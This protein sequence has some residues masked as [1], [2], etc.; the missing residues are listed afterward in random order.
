GFALLSCGGGSTGPG[1]GAGKI[2]ITPSNDSIVIGTSVSLSA[3]VMNAQGQVVNGATVFWNTSNANVATVSSNGTVTGVDTGTVQIAASANGVSGIAGI[4]VLPQ[5]VASVSVSPPTV[6]LKVG[7]TQRLAALLFD[8]DGNPL[9]ARV[10]TWSS[11]D[12]TVA[13]VDNSGLVTAVAVGPATITAT[14]E[15]KS[16]SAAVSVGAQVASKITVAPTTVGITVGQTSQLAATVLDAS[17]AMIAG[18]P[19]AWT[20]DKP[21]VAS[22]S[23]TGLGTDTVTGISVG[24]ATITAT[25]GAAHTIVPVTVSPSPASAVIISPGSATLFVTQQ[26]QLSATVTDSHGNPLSGQTVTWISNNPAA[27]TVSGSGNVNAVAPGSAA[28]T[29]MSGAAH[30]NASITVKLVPV[31]SVNVNPNLVPLFVGQTAQLGV[32]LVDSAGD[33]LSAVGR[34]VSW[35]SSKGG[36]ATVSASGLV[37]A[38]GVGATVI[39]ATV[40]GQQGFA[41]ITV[42]PVP[43]ANVNVTPALDTLTLGQAVQLK[44]QPVDSAGNPLAG[45]TVT[46]AVSDSSVA[47]VTSGGRVVSQGVGTA[48]ITATSEGQVGTATVVVIAVPVASVTVSPPNKTMTVGDTATF[49]ATTKDAQGHVLTGRAIA[50]SSSNTAVATVDST[51]LVTAVAAGSAN[52]TAT[53]E[54]Q[55]GSSA[56]TV[57]PVPVGQVIVAPKDTTITAGDSAQFSAQPED[58]KGNPLSGRSVSWSSSDITIATVS[59]SGMVNA[60]AAGGPVTITATSEGVPGSTSVTVAAAVMTGTSARRATASPN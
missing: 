51:G 48:T 58:A 60:V 54:G 4:S 52:I 29:A 49:S 40:E 22:L 25:S 31:S 34:A 26:L 1:N 35:K 45:R 7:G 20:I 39:T 21:S 19:V 56:V 24:T 57:N 11:S 12:P 53:S 38:Q 33:T 44:A 47:L 42:A 2:V 36:V 30:G 17:G 16:G 14:S 46:W 8:A 6:T 10:V 28:I 50:W 41:S 43:V 18:A 59:S 13:T 15:G 3:K 55:S 37:T 32:V 5:P 27:A 9:T 23:S